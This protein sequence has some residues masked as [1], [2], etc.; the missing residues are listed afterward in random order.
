MK[1]VILLLVGGIVLI[2]GGMFGITLG[3]LHINEFFNPK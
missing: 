1:R 3:I 2:L